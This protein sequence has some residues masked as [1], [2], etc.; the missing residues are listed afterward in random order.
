MS[1]LLVAVPLALLAL[2][3]CTQN[4]KLWINEVGAQRLELY[5]DEPNGNALA[6]HG[7]TLDWVALDPSGVNAPQ[8]G[9]IDLSGSIPGGGFLVLFEDPSGPPGGSTPA[10]VDDFFHRSRAGLA[11]A[12]DALGPTDSALGY[13]FRVHGHEFRYVFPFFYT[14]DDTDDTVRF[15]PRGRPNIGGTFTEDN[16]LQPVTRTPTMGQTKGRTIRRKTVGVGG[17]DSPVDRDRE[18][19]WQT[20]DESWGSA[21]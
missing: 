3:G 19:D 11:V 16:S 10:N 1:R 13:A 21:K 20:D 8:S 18:A 4:R 6:L 17:V 14:Y 2:C 9:S 12:P 7:Q 15:G 5:L